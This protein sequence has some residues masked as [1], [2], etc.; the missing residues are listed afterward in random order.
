LDAANDALG[1]ARKAASATAMAIFVTMVIPPFKVGQDCPVAI[2]HVVS[3]YT[4]TRASL[5]FTD[6]HVDERSFIKL[7]VSSADDAPEGLLGAD[8][9]A[10]PPTPRLN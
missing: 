5:I 1:T 9:G 2:M 6:V 7:R 8:A 3:I 10:E 4:Y